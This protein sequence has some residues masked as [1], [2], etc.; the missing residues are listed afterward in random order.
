MNKKAIRENHL[1]SLLSASRRMTTAEAVDALGVSVATARRLFNEMEKKGSLYAIMAEYSCRVRC[2]TIP[3]KAAKKSIPQ[4]SS[5]LE[6]PP[7][8]WFKMETPFFLTA[9][10]RLCR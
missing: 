3:L 2:M 6:K 7:L 10:Q 8:I 4:K 5:A 9:A 1:L